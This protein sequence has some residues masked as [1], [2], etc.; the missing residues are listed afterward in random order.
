MPARDEVL[1]VAGREV[2]ITNPD[3]VFFPRTGLTKLEMVRYYIAVA[4]GAVRGVYGRPMVL[5]RFV[6]GAEGEVFFQK[7]APFASAAPA[8]GQEEDR[9]R[10]APL[11]LRANRGGD[12]GPRRGA[13]GRAREPRLHR[14]HP[15]P[16][17]GGRPRPPR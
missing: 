16:G 7:R 17:A 9:A 11:P 15:P 4:E 1:E 12:R 14:P 8:G 6:N 3:K 2:T 10:G 5:K 13:A